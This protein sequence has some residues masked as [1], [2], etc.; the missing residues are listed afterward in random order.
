MFLTFCLHSIFTQALNEL[1]SVHYILDTLTFGD[2]GAKV[3]IYKMHRKEV[4]RYEQ[5]INIRN[6]GRTGT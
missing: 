5:I 4:E 1:E 6:A 3:E 2:W